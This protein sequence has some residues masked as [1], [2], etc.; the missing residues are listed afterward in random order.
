MW[1]LAAKVKDMKDFSETNHTTCHRMVRKKNPV[2]RKK[3]S[4]GRDDSSYGSQEKFCWT[5]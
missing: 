5:Q 4:V 1:S 2:G 3:N